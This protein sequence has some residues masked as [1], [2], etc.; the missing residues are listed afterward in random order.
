MLGM[1]ARG[2]SP[3][4]RGAQRRSGAASTAT[5]TSTASVHHDPD[6]RAPRAR[7]TRGAVHPASSRGRLR[8]R[9]GGRRRRDR[10]GRDRRRDLRLRHDRQGGG[11]RLRAAGIDLIISDHHL[12]GGPLPEAF[13][14]INP[15]SRAADIPDKDL[16]AVGVA[17]KLALALDARAG[18]QR[19]R[20]VSTCSTS[21]RSRRSRTSRRCAA[22]IACSCA[23]RARA[24]GRHHEAP[25]SAR[26]CAPRAWRARRS[27]RAASGSCSRRGS[28]RS[29]G[30]AARSAAS[31]CCSTDGG[32]SAG[33]SP[34]RAT[35]KSST[36]SARRWIATRSRAG[37]A[38][39]RAHGPRRHVRHR[40]RRAG[41]APRRRSGS[42]RRGWSRKSCRPAML[43]ALEGGVGK[44]SGRSIPAFD[45]H[46]ALAACGDL[47]LQHG[48]HR[49]AA[50]AH[51]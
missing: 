34:W 28:T 2:R 26:S 19:E 3:G 35:A 36:A 10:C 29:A 50:R 42:W 24:A 48:G 40:A 5:T 15:S 18:R 47:L 6:A 38:T 37:H 16:A 44:G 11:R 51:D 8:S 49:A 12:P 25:G 14:V 22:R 45:L 13:A 46:A 21:S 30:S 31:S 17:F 41:L 27:P 20:R 4:P 9:D 32:R 39:R 7:R 23:L 1:D 33:Q 43:I